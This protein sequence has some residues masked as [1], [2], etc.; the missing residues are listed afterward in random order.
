MVFTFLDGTANKG[1]CQVIVEPNRRNSIAFLS[2]I[3]TEMHN[4]GVN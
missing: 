1:T 3:E 4:P 2:N